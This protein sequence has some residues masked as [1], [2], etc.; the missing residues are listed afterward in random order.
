MENTA[1]KNE[2]ELLEK[3]ACIALEKQSDFAEVIGDN[4]WNVDMGKGEISFG[5]N[6]HFPIQIVGTI[7]HAAQSWLWAWANTKSGLPPQLLEQSFQL[8][9]Y[10]DENNIPLLS[11]DSFDFSKDELHMIGIIASGMFNS[12]GYYIAD[13]GQGAMVVTIKNELIDEQRKDNHHAILTVFPQVISQ[14]EMNHRYA[15][16][17]YLSAKGYHITENDNDLSASKNGNTIT[18]TFDDLSRLTELKG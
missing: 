12:S 6:L 13:Y 18:A 4:N 8:K 7:S 17:H 16:K 1:C 11:N 15:L 9:A 10:G 3:Y 14:Y 5:P 2:Q